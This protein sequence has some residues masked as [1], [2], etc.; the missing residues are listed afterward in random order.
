MVPQKV[1][2]IRR[3][4]SGASCSTV[5]VPYNNGSSTLYKKRNRRINYDPLWHQVEVQRAV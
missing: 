5:M 1:E 2:I 3:L 4:E